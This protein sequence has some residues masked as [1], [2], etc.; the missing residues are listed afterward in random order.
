MAGAKIAPQVERFTAAER[1]F[2]RLA[3]RKYRDNE[4]WFEF[5]SFA[6]GMD[7]PVFAGGHSHLDVLGRPLYLLLKEMWLDLGRRQGYVATATEE[8]STDGARRQ[9]TRGRTPTN[10]RHATKERNVAPT[11]SSSRK[12]LPKSRG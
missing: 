7:S 3:E 1:R 5:E 10:R 6:F 2:L 11:Y 12:R 4:N 9:T 8:I